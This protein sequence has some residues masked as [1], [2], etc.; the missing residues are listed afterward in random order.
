MAKTGTF[1]ESIP[2]ERVDAFCLRND[3]IQENENFIL[4]SESGAESELGI[5]HNDET[6]RL[7]SCVVSYSISKYLISILN[8]AALTYTTQN[9]TAYRPYLIGQS[10]Y[11]SSYTNERGDHLTD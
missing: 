10:K 1:L 5:E 9:I 2:K 11:R 8:I 7:A 4:I 3:I 6:V